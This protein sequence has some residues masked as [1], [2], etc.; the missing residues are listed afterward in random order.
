MLPYFPNKE[1]YTKGSN[2]VMLMETQSI[3]FASNKQSFG[4]ICV[5]YIGGWIA[6]SWK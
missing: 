5:K 4:H 3:W 2:Y 6:E 1:N